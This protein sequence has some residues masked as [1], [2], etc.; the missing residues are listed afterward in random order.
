MNET[1]TV[2]VPNKH[3]KAEARRRIEGGFDK[4]AAQIGGKAQ[5]EQKWKGDTMR[6]KAATMG[7]TI[8]GTLIV[9]EEEV[10]IDVSLPWLL[11]KLAG[12]ISGKLA[13]NTQL[14][15]DKK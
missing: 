1:I 14:L 8:D 12:P 3:T 10:Q 2:T 15:L 9:R 13:K 7:Q 4:V 6:F 11:A 5:V